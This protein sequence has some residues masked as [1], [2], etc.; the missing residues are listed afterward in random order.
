MLAENCF[1]R[2]MQSLLP[3]FSLLAFGPLFESRRQ[4]LRSLVF[5]VVVSGN[6]KIADQQRTWRKK[7][8]FSLSIERRQLGRI[9]PVYLVGICSCAPSTDGSS[10]P[11][12]RAA[13]LVTRFEHQKLLNPLQLSIFTA[14]AISTDLYP[15]QSAQSHLTNSP[16]SASSGSPVYHS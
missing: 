11:S 15:Q 9:T 13:F 16:F 14:S 7:P 8:R 10:V 2:E 5:G 4:K 3:H 1:C 12:I 6:F